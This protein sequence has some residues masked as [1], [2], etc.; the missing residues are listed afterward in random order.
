MATSTDPRSRSAWREITPAAAGAAMDAAVHSAI[1]VDPL[2]H[3]IGAPLDA[4]ERLRC[5]DLTVAG[6]GAV[7]AA[8][9]D[10]LPGLAIG[11]VRIVDPARYSPSNVRA[12]PVTPEAIGRPKCA[13]VGARLKARSPETRVFVLHERFECLTA[14]DLQSS[15]A[16]ALAG[17]NLLLTVAVAQR[18]CALGQALVQGTVHGPTGVAQVRRT[19]PVAGRARSCPCCM[20][21]KAEERELQRQTRFACD[22]SGRTLANPAGPTG[23]LSAVSALAGSLMAIEV[24]RWA[25][26]LDDADVI[27]EYCA[28]SR[29]SVV[30]PLVSNPRCRVEHA[31]WRRV[32]SA[33]ALAELSPAHIFALAGVLG[34]SRH[35]QSSLEIEGASWLSRGDCAC[36]VPPVLDRFVS[37]T[38]GVATLGPCARCG[39][40]L[41][42]D[43]FH[44]HVEVHGALFS[45]CLGRT[46]AELGAAGASTA[47]VRSPS[48]VVL[49]VGADPPARMAGRR[50]ACRAKEGR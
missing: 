25:L 4:H 9:V 15:G 21:D 38:H 26:G 2:A 11:T 29:A 24:L 35:A 40:E 37:P 49:V 41:R 34:P 42:A 47:I 33:R 18:A 44:T 16:I 10:L 32:R 19:V 5:L 8:F 39:S 45:A 43:S 22:G 20:W 27:V 12:Q 28:L 7:G 36:A 6:V 48:G 3:L 46:L 23:A 14:A 1:A 31:P 30:S 13:V 17:D 50:P